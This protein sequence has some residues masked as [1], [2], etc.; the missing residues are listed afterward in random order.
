MP[1]VTVCHCYQ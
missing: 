1:M